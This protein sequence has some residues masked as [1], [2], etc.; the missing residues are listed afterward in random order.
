M[1]IDLLIG[2]IVTY[3]LIAIALAGKKVSKF[4]EES[5]KRKAWEDDKTDVDPVTGD[6]TSRYNGLRYDKH[7]CP[8]WR[9][10]Q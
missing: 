2:F 5:K 4:D 1:G 3:A 10:W 8:K 6:Y 9:E 7:G